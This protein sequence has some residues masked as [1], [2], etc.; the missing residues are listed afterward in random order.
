MAYEVLPFQFE[1]SDLRANYPTHGMLTPSKIYAVKTR[2]PRSAKIRKNS[3]PRQPFPGRLPSHR[4]RDPPHPYLKNLKI[5]NPIA[6]AI[7]PNNNTIPTIC[8][9]STNLSLGLRPLIISISVNKAWPP[10]RAGIGSTF[11]KASRILKIAV[12]DQKLSQSHSEGNTLA[13]VPQTLP[14]LSC[15]LT[16]LRRKQQPEVTDIIDQRL[17]ALVDTGR[18]SLQ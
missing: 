10:S 1:Y 2:H 12:K 18:N 4:R 3:H 7:R 11:I 6:Y 5:S 8:E 16:S 13:M 17:N 14:R 15:T 9:Y